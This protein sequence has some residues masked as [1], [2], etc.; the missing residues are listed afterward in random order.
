MLITKDNRPDNRLAP[1]Q[2]HVAALGGDVLVRPLTA[3]R[4]HELD[5]KFPADDA[6]K[7]V[8]R[9]GYSS[10]VIA[11]IVIN[12]DGTPLWTAEE[13]ATTVDHRLFQELSTIVKNV[14]QGDKAPNA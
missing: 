14:M 3:L 5:Q 1:K 13:L 6:G 7:V 9:V 8:D 2:V 11:E 10:A 12:P 4:Q